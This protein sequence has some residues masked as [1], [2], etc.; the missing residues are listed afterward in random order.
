RE[1][2]LVELEQKTTENSNKLNEYEEERKSILEE[3]KELIESAK[4][5]LA[6]KTAEGLSDSFIT[7]YDNANKWWKSI[8]WMIGASLCLIG[9]LCLGIWIMDNIQ[10]QWFMI[11][12]RILLLPIPIS[13]A[14]FCAKQYTKQ[15][16]IIEDYA[17]KS[18]I[19]KA[20]VGFSEQL[21]KNGNN[22]DDIEYTDYIQ[23]ALSEIHKDPLRPRKEERTINLKQN[24]LDQV[25]DLAKKI[26]DLTKDK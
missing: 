18:T 23:K 11:M 1:N 17:Y 12:G 14:V 22:N 21:K 10:E 6:Y 20:I 3:A 25:V 26:V 5:A 16:N 9:T 4:K 2:R 7:Q 19:A 15:K 24:Q 8:F 13:G